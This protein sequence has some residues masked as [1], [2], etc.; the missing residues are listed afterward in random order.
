MDIEWKGVSGVDI[1]ANAH[2]IAHLKAN[3]VFVGLM[4]KKW[5]QIMHRVMGFNCEC[6]SLL[7][8]WVD[9]QMW[10]VF[11]LKQPKKPCE[12]C[13][14]RVEPFYGSMDL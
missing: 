2:V 14:W 10:V 5:N 13:S 9:E 3:E 1:H 12:A 7:W 4:S 8:V 6:N 11:H